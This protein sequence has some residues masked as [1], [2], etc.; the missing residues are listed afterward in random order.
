MGEMRIFINFIGPCWHCYTLKEGKVRFLLILFAGTQPLLLLKRWVCIV[1]VRFLWLWDFYEFE[2]RLKCTEKKLEN[3][4]TSEHFPVFFQ[5][6][7]TYSIFCRCLFFV[8]HFSLF[9][10]MLLVI[11][12]SLFRR[13]QCRRIGRV[14]VDGQTFE[15]THWQW[16]GFDR[17]RVRIIGQHS[18]CDSGA[19]PVGQHWGHIS[20]W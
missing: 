7:Y 15:Y 17:L 12:W 14:S 3:V 8:W 2:N 13:T 11:E 20:H 10:L 18:Q 16:Q 4:H 6:T 1:I 19:N 9:I 5:C